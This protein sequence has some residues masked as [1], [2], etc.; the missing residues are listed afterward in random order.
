M[1]GW[2]SKMLAAV[3]T[4]AEM[5]ARGFGLAPDAFTRRM[6]R[7]PLLLAPT[8]AR[9][10]RLPDAAGELPGSVATRARAAT[11]KLGPA[12]ALAWAVGTS[13]P[14]C[15]LPEPSWRHS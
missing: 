1:D 14:T 3:E 9:R 7:G 10:P 5:A 8:G 11:P 4:A 15:R 12:A 13:V 2:G 6:R